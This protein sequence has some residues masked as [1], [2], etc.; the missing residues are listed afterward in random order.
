MDRRR[1]VRE[2]FAHLVPQST[3]WRDEDRLG[4]INNSMY[5]TYEESAR[6]AYLD[7]VFDRSG[8]W[9]SGSIIVAHIECDFVAQLHHPTDFEM[10][11][12]IAS[13]GGSSMTSEGALF[14]GDEVAAVTSSV[15]VW[16]DYE[17]DRSIRIPDQARAAIRAFERRTPEER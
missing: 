10:G 4:H 5:F 8:S 17:A 2:D 1:P 15:I 7:R 9:T 11:F 13:L 3:R 16:F 12:R 14:V 6:I